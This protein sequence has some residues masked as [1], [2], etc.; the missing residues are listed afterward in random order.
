M[1]I[2]TTDP[3]L[4]TIFARIDEGS[5]DLQPDFQRAEV[6]QLPKKKLLIDTILRGWQ[7]PPVHVILNEE[8]DIQEVLDGQ[9]RLSAIR[10]FMYNKFKINGYIEP[11]DDDIKELDGL[12]F[13]KLPQKIKNRLERYAIRVFEIVEYNQGEPGELFNRLNE[14]LKLTSAEKRNAYVGYLRNQIKS[15][16]DYLGD[17][18]LDKNFLGFSNQRMAY[19]DLFIKLCYMLE[20]NS[21]IASYT[22]KQLNDRA[23]EDEPFDDSV[24]ELVRSAILVLSKSRRVLDSQGQGIHITKATLISWL[25]FFANTLKYNKELDG[26]LVDFFVNFEMNRFTFKEYGDL[27]GIFEIRNLDQVKE[28]LEEFNFRAVSRV[29]TGSSLLIRDFIISLFF[30]KSYPGLTE[31]FDLMKV[32]NLETAVEALINKTNNDAISVVNGYSDA[33]LAGV[34][35]CQ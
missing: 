30:M 24:I 19:H 23:R 11:L 1:K 10:D 7:V 13:D 4:R 33:V 3:D 9:Q 34:T 17:N 35:V 31:I 25:Y 26:K 32:G 29:M 5:L 27:R 14:S 8:S 12:T 18:G 21:L 16:V 20:K 2:N 28:L 6:W 22:E 15:L